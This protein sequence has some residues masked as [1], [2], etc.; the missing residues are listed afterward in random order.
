VHQPAGAV[1]LREF[2]AQGS[3]KFPHT[4]GIGGQRREINVQPT[5]VVVTSRRNDRTLRDFR[6]YHLQFQF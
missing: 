4:I 3:Y 5:H 6:E 2:P 1:L